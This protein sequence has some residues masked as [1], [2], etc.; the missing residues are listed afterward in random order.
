MLLRAWRR[1]EYLRQSVTPAGFDD[2]DAM[3]L[4]MDVGYLAFEDRGFGVQ[5]T[6]TPACDS[7][8][9]IILCQTND[10]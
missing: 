9:S 8:L 10:I 1:Y 5:G 7:K 4:S 3:T 6:D 2:D